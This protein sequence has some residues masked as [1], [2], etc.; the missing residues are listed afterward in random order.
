MTL[1]GKRGLFKDWIFLSLVFC[2]ASL[3]L[4]SYFILFGKSKLEIVY[5]NWDGP[6]YAVIAQTLYNPSAISQVPWANYLD[7]KS[8]ASSFPL[9]SVF[10][11]LFGFIG[12]NRSMIFVSLIFS[13]GCILTFY[14]LVKKF[15]L[16]A[17]P[18][19]LSTLFIFLTPRWFISSHIGSS[20]PLFIF[21]VLVSLIFFLKEKYLFSAISLALA[22]LT[23][24]QGI[25]F[26]VAYFF[27]IFLKYLMS[28]RK[29]DKYFFL[30][31]LR[32]YYPYFLSIIVLLGLFSYFQFIY[33][34]FWAFFDALNKWD[35][36]SKFPFEVFLSFPSQTVPTF[37]LED[38]YW[39]YFMDIVAIAML[40]RK[41]LYPFA[42]MAGF[43]FFPLIF[44]KHIDLGRYN[45]PMLPFILIAIDSKSLNRILLIATILLLPALYFFTIEFMTWNR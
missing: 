30:N 20:E 44:L 36:R 14:Y 23:R 28:K 13:L 37:W 39:I 31:V 35:Y 12:I 45:L 21:F 1:T 15:K 19:I 41:K 2:A 38:L 27:A 40:V 4:Y 43:Y 32:K 17:N 11:R 10:I 42:I 9:Y 3:T 29:I 26:F 6:I 16:S 22:Q 8:F 5:Q 7:P 33:G 34:D 24:S 18:L 25:I